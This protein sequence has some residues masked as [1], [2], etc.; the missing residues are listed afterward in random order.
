MESLYNLSGQVAGYFS[1]LKV[2]PEG[3]AL[4]SDA[5]YNREAA[6]SPFRAIRNRPSF[7]LLPVLLLLALPAGSSAPTAGAAAAD[8]Y[9]LLARLMSDSDGERH[10]APRRLVESGDASLV[11]A[12]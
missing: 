6:M 5:R 8:G 12:P 1:S 7:R 2:P 9:G 3:V 4:D 10:A 11:P